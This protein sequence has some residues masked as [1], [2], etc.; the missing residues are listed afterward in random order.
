MDNK[1]M[2]LFEKINFGAAILLV[3]SFPFGYNL[4]Y[5]ALSLWVATFVI[6]KIV[7]SKKAK[8]YF[9][10]KKG[11]LL[12]FA[13]S[14]LFFLFFFISILIRPNFQ[15]NVNELESQLSFIAFPIIFLFANQAY[16]IKK[17]ILIKVFV[18]AVFL[19]SAYSLYVAFSNSLRIEDGKLI[20]RSIIGN[21]SYN[22]GDNI[23]ESVTQGG[24]YFFGHY[25]SPLLHPTYYAMYLNFGIFFMLSLWKNS[26]GWKVKSIF[27]FLILLFSLLIFLLGSKGGIITLLIS[28]SLFFFYHL[29]YKKQIYLKILGILFF[30]TITFLFL[31]SPRMKLLLNKFKSEQLEERNLSTESS[32]M[33]LKIW[34]ASIE[35]I[36]EHYLFGLGP[37][38]VKKNIS[39]KLNLNE[40]EA[41]KTYDPHNQYFTTIIKLGIF[42]L[43]IFLLLLIY[44]SIKSIKKKEH[45][46]FYLLIIVAINGLFETIYGLAQGIVVINF[47]YGLLIINLPI[48]KQKKYQ[49]ETLVTS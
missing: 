23:L 30:I 33:R 34:K 1:K 48:K 12:I 37:G 2:P 17:D 36:E 11:Y 13:P 44:P 22:R 24:N 28:T 18:L 38:N 9:Y 6:E 43:I 29:F 3:L 45:L 19:T 40:K 47:F 32:D 41:N 20:F 5:Y 14:T 27:V 39:L 26:T 15:K 35:I 10:E 25:I 8:E 16:R 49:N 42:G 46:L 4:S 7:Y 31:Q 21:K